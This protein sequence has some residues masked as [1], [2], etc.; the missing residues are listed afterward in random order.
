MATAVTMAEVDAV[1]TDTSTAKVDA[2]A[3]VHAV[4]QVVARAEVG[5]VAQVSAH[6]V[7]VANEAVVVAVVEAEVVVTAEVEVVV[8]AEDVA[9]AQAV[10]EAQ[11]RGH[12]AL[13][14]PRLLFGH[15][16]VLAAPLRLECGRSTKRSIL[17]KIVLPGL[18][19]VF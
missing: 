8:L 11:V 6:T 14:A 12:R 5:A 3:E 9:A 10:V 15:A 1:A 19:L 4:A 7:D 13:V 18:H 17:T 16:T 2:T